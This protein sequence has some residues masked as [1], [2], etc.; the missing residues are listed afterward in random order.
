MNNSLENTTEKK[1]TMEKFIHNGSK[2]LKC[3]GIN[4]VNT[5]WD[6][7]EEN[8]KTSSGDIKEKWYIL[9]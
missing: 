1:F 7:A 2:T 9:K 6:W 4:L 3:L 5:V 8:I